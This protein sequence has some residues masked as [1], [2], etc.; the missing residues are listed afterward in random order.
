[1]SGSEPARCF[2]SGKQPGGFFLS[3]I[4]EIH[5]GI[6]HVWRV[7]HVVMEYGAIP[8]LLCLKSFFSLSLCGLLE[9]ENENSPTDNGIAK[10]FHHKLNVTIK[11]I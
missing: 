8:I 6:G 1:M 4:V 3:L 10:G 7:R 9:R 5:L 11:F 2:K